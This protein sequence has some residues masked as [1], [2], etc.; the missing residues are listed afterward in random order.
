M[1]EYQHNGKIWV[2]VTVYSFALEFF[3]ID[4][5]KANVITLSSGISDVCKY[6]MCVY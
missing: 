1:K 3:K 6:N 4:L 5:A 2:N